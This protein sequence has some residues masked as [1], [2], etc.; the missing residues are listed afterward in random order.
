MKNISDRPNKF[1]Y[2]IW[3]SDRHTVRLFVG[4]TSI[5]WA[6][7]ELWALLFSVPPGISPGHNFFVN[8]IQYDL[9]T[10]FAWPALFAIQGVAAIYAVITSSRQIILLLLDSVLG[11][12]LWGGIAVLTVIGFDATIVSSTQLSLTMVMFIITL[13]LTMRAEYGH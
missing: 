12:L 3:Q 4:L 1:A 9:F 10:P 5:L 11:C 2:M 8:Q 7:V 6:C 13:W